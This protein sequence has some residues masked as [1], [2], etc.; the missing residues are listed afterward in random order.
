MYDDVKRF[1]ELLDRTIKNWDDTI[2]ERDKALDKVTRLL[3]Y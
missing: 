2:V 1:K 3:E